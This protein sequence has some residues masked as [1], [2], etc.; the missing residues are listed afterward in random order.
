MRHE[1]RAAVVLHDDSFACS[2]GCPHTARQ[3]A[4]DVADQR[5]LYFIMED[6]GMGCFRDRDD[7]YCGI[8]VVS[9]IEE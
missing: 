1:T 6:H 8:Y 2:V 9:L 7:V 4:E 3:I 5:G